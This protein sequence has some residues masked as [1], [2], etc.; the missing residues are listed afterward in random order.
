MAEYYFRTT[1]PETIAGHIEAVKA[2]E[3]MSKVRKDKDLIIDLVTES[4][5][6]ALYLVD[7]DHHRA[8]EVERRIEEKYP[9]FRIQSY[10]TS[11]KASGREHLR[12]YLVYKPTINLKSIAKGKTGLSDIACRNFLKTATPEAIDRYQNMILR[13]EGWETPLI[14]VTHKEETGEHR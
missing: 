7:D 10:R 6:E 4:K 1:P 9:D 8:I 3:I 11:G 5:D 13:S 2:A 14:E 12:M